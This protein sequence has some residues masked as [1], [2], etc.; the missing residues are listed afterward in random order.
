M[1]TGNM[2]LLYKNR[3][4]A[5]VKIQKSKY[6]LNMMNKKSEKIRNL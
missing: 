6:K 3:K 1:K 5:K 2:N 4:K